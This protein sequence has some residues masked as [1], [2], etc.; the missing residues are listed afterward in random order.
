[1]RT[2]KNEKGNLKSE[3]VRYCQ[4]NILMIITGKEICNFIRE[5]IDC[6]C[7]DVGKFSKREINMIVLDLV[8]KGYLEPA[9]TENN[10]PGY[11][12]SEKI[13]EL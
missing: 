7:Y 3:I 8:M 12:S 2:T 4:E 10:E 11:F 9:I 6:F 13:R 1:M 5:N